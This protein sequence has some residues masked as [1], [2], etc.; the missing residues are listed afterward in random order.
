MDTSTTPSVEARELQTAHLTIRGMTCAA[1]VRRVERALTKVAGVRGAEAS[2]ATDRATVTFDPTVTSTVALARA[3]ADAGYEV[4]PVQPALIEAEP[5]PANPTGAGARDRV[6][7]PS[8][9]TDDP[10]DTSLLRDFALAAL[11]TAPLLGLGMSH[12]AIPGAE[13]P[14]S[15]AVQLVLATVVVFGPGARFFR[16]ARNALRHRTSDMNTLVSLG[17]GAAYAYSTVAVLFPSVFSH[18][19]HGVLPHVYFEAAGAIVSFVLL[20][21]LLE[22]RA[23]RR[24]ADAVRGLVALQPTTARR[25][26]DE[27]QEQE[28]AVE[29]LALGDRVLVR[30]GERIPTDGRVLRGASAVDESMLTGESMPVD[31]GVGASVFG[32]TMNQ[33]GSFTFRVERRGG[34]TALARI[35]DAVEQA[36]AGKAP[37]ARL[38][39]VVSSW[40]VPAVLLIALI[41]FA[42]WLVLDPTQQGLATATE[43][44]VAV[45]VIACPCALGLATPA[46]VAVGTARGA[47]LGVLVKGGAVLES[48]SRVET[49]LLDK[50]GTVT[51]GMPELTDV[52]AVDGDDGTLLSLVASAETQSEHP[53]ARA[54]VAG[55]IARGHVVATPED[56]ASKAGYGIQAIVGGR[57]VRVGT[58]A[59]LAQDDVDTATLE[60]RADELASR[61]RTPFFVAVDARLA[62]LVAVADGVIEPARTAVAALRELG[63]EIVMVTGD[64]ERTARAVAAELGIE[65][66]FAE[67]KP[68]EKAVLVN[69]ERARGRVVAMVGDGVNDA[70]ALAAA[71]VGVAVGGGADI[72]IAAADV[73]LLHGGI[74]TLPAALR[75]GRA[76]LRNIRQNLFWAFVYNVIGIPIAAGLLYPLT[77]WLLSPVIASAAMS[78]SSVSVLL[79]SLRLRRFGRPR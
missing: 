52:V 48:T 5:G 15:R 64:R 26:G 57:R 65:R 29:M 42:V 2:F 33:G 72:A 62:G 8:A 13:G 32:G 20:G 41:T 61:G 46:A 44:F 21:K 58:S 56:F 74:G 78:L 60:P 22:R 11:L 43:R 51:A 55:A 45:L 34:E 14:I 53:I 28:V 66:V 6:T 59:W 16:L 49:V 25:L 23:K 7:P 63:V 75:L 40:F 71:D 67:V 10:E 47:E 69:A 79:N 1:C 73:A 68:E 18:T 70:P 38:A 31:K 54:I 3:V 50:T 37:I 19:E 77:G 17:A 76:T 9:T 24:L 36:Q 35:V 39:D 12:G 30:P 4:P 27:D